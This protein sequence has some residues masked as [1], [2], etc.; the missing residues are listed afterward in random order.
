MSDLQTLKRLNYTII[1]CKKCPRLSSYIRRV[2]KEKVKRFNNQKYWGKPLTGFGDINA[3]LLLVGLAPAAHGGNRTGRM[4]TGDSSG[5]W[6]AKVLYEIGFAS[7]PTS[8]RADDGFTLNDVYIT[9]TLRCAPPQNK[10]LKVELDNCAI[11][12][13]KE[14]DILKNVKVIICLGKVAFDSCCKLL[15]IKGYKFG[16]GKIIHHKQCTV[17]ASYHPSRQNT[18]T[19]R[20][21]WNQWLAIFLK[22]K[23]ILASYETGSCNTHIQ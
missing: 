9:A 14:F 17:I 16:H 11:F 23:E 20:L 7:K 2:A 13:K 4:F 8:E 19:G 21:T 6:V 22:A 12:L 15:H 10:P 5:N 3:K 1:K 18:Q